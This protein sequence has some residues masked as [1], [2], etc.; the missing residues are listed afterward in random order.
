MPGNIELLAEVIK[1]LL[2][3]ENR[4]KDGMSDERWSDAEMAANKR[5][6]RD[7]ALITLRAIGYKTEGL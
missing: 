3:A 6:A 2:R 4:Y 5:A 1:Q 7:N